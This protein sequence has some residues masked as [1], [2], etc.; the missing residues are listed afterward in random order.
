[1]GNKY[2]WVYKLSADSLIRKVLPSLLEKANYSVEQ[3]KN[4][5]YAPG[6]IPIMMVAHVDTV[7]SNLPDLIFHDQKQ[8]VIWSPNGIGG[9][10]RAG[11]SAIIELIS[12]GYK[13][14]ILF[15]DGEEKGGIGAKEAAKNI[16]PDVTYV[17]E[18]DRKGRNEAIFY[19]CKND[20][21][22]KYIIDF[23]FVE[24]LGSFTDISFLCPD[25]GIAGVN[26]SIGYY[27]AHQSTEYVMLDHWEETVDKVAKM[28]DNPPAEIFQYVEDVA[29]NVVDYTSF[30][31]SRY[32][33]QKIAY[34]E[35]DYYSYSGWDDEIS[36]SISSID[37]VEA[38]GGEIKEWDDFI[39]DYGSAIEKEALTFIVEMIENFCYIDL[40]RNSYVEE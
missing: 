4:Y 28:L 9:D 5:L 1:M 12:R 33:T 25:W 30:Y 37:L 20:E 3:G 8:N 11:I 29:L 24:G 16:R 27:N 21:F 17:I 14:H 34:D 7:H 31:N 39:L 15:T 13:P 18:L 10:D 35:Y 6:S 26:L 32:P 22:T 40:E 19:D 36:I 38:F 23:G 2:D